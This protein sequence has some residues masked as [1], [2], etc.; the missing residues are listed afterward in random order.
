MY[1]H[2]LVP[3]DGS[4]LAECVLPHV[5]TI[6]EGCNV[7]KVT[8]IRAVGPLHIRGGLESRFTPEEREELENH[9][10]DNASNYLDQLVMQFKGTSVMAETEV[11][12]GDIV[13]SIIDFADKNGVDLIIL[14]THG[15]SGVSR[16]VWGSVTD[17]ILRAA[18]V[19]IMMVRA[20]GCFPGI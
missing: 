4:E 5:K 7:V 16:W 11:L 10:E 2:I 9:A 20:P 17:R 6:A 13:D 1:Q 15:R 18:C 19:P 12:H 14:A 8:F 3:L